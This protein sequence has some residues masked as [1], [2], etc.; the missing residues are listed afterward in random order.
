MTIVSTIVTLL[1]F[2]VIVVVH[3]YGHF[4]AAR[5]NGIM[6]E[7]FAVGMGPVIFSRKKG[8][9]LYSIRAFPIG[10]FCKMLGEEDESDD[11]RSFSSKKVWQRIVVCMAGVVMNFL[12]AVVLGCI[13][14]S[15]TSMR[16]PL[17]TDV[18]DGNPAQIAGILPGDRILKIDGKK[19][20][21]HDYVGHYLGI[22]GS[23]PVEIVLERNGSRVSTVLTPYAEPLSNGVLKYYMGVIVENKV[24][25]FSNEKGE[26]ETAGFAET[27]KGAFGQSL[28][29]VSTVIDGVSQLFQRK[30][31]A[32]DLLGPIGMGQ[33]V[34]SGLRE[35][36]QMEEESAMRDFTIFAVRLAML[37]SA[38]LAVMNLLPIPALDGGRI[39]FLIIEGVR[40]R[41]IDPEKEGW[42]HLA[43]FALVMLLGIL[44]AFNDIRRIF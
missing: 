4:V 21:A 29:Y 43:G 19:I 1:I 34:D 42:I 3:E 18:I 5:K 2:T 36:V 10:G 27:V 33:I 14:I 15:A 25:F 16:T 12:L 6:V 22:V 23:N 24:G 26:Y 32:D 38:N 31:D 8:E 40:R 9:T 11:P 20:W 35:A 30:V 28:F 7:E 17:I 39:V 37:L 44:V 13:I 41:P